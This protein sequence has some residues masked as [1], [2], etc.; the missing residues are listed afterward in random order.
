MSATNDSSPSQSQL[1]SLLEHY[2]SGRY[3]DAEKLAISITQQFPHHPFS[4]KVLA[5]VLKR[6]GRIS[7]ALV[8]SQKAVEIAP[9]DAEAHSNL[10]NT[11]KALG[12]LVQAEESYRQAIALEHDH[13]EVHYNLALAHVLVLWLVC[14]FLPPALICQVLSTCCPSCYG[15]RHLQEQSPLLFGWQLMPLIFCLFVSAP[16]PAL[17]S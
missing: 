7:E 1:N 2:Q 15:L 11:L 17:S 5:A 14:S 16:L 6:T 9:E 13:A 10:G 12:R 8:A 3:E 4:W